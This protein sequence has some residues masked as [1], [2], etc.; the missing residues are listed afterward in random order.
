MEDEF[1]IQAL[2]R[3]LRDAAGVD[4]RKPPRRSGAAGS[5]PLGPGLFEWAGLDAGTAPPDAAAPPAPD[6]P[7]VVAPVS[8]ANR[9]RPFGRRQEPAPDPTADHRRGETVDLFAERP[10]AARAPLPESFWET[11]DLQP[12]VGDAVA[13]PA[14]RR[15]RLR[16]LDRPEPPQET[17]LHAFDAEFTDVP[18][19]EEIAA[20]ERSAEVLRQVVDRQGPGAEAAIRPVQA[21]LLSLANTLLLERDQLEAKL[22]D[23][24]PPLVLTP[25][26]RRKGERDFLPLMTAND[27]G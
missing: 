7:P 10:A 25:L 26:R 12:P 9:A 8:P 15:P 27:R 16:R 24:Q 5:E 18:R 17:S 23:S 1:D 3:Q 13:P 4:R 22:S 21:L 19:P 20:A 6:W 14:P 2:R 11:G